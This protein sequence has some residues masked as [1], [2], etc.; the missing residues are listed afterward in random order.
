MTKLSGV[1]YPGLVFSINAGDLAA[2]GAAAS[3]SVAGY[4][5][6]AKI[7]K[8]SVHLLSEFV[9][10]TAVTGVT[11]MTGRIT[12]S[13]TGTHNNIVNYG[14]ATT[15]L[16]T[17]TDIQ[18]TTPVFESKTTDRDLVFQIAMATG[19]EVATSVTA[20]AVRVWFLYTVLGT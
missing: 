7:P 2:S 10:D 14:A 19:S 9:V 12:T 17:S 11:T 8:G 15:L 3:G 5:T 1:N 6:L 13:D 16:S 18:N 20:G 4:V